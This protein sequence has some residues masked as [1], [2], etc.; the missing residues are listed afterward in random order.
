MKISEMINNLQEFMEEHG[1]IDCWYAVDDEG[2]GYQEIYF[3][4]SK[5]YV[6]EDKNVYTSIEDVEDCDLSIEDVIPICI[7]N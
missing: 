1:D 3:D 4:P 7:V 5:Y 6:D 2:N